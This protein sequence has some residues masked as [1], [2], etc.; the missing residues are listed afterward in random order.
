VGPAGE[1]SVEVSGPVGVDDFSFLQR[2]VVAGTGIGLLP[3]FLCGGATRE[4]TL[5][6]VLPEYVARGGA[7]HLVY[8]SARYLPQR[9]VVFRDF[10]VAALA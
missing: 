7:L 1:E 4:G 10:L 5:V 8:P 3:A 9:A 6:R 2:I